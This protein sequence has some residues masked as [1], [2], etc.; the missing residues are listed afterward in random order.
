MA[1]GSTSQDRAGTGWMES[2][3]V[4]GE[5]KKNSLQVEPEA[6]PDATI[7]IHKKQNKIVIHSR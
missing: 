3:F 2:E 6:Q 1:Y 7:K 4:D 5:R